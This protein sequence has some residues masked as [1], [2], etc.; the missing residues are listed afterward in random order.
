MNWSVHG[1]Q[2]VN[3]IVGVKG[4]LNIKV[5][6]DT[7]NAPLQGE[8]IVTEVIIKCKNVVVPLNT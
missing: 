8:S 7:I 1:E 4:T 5:K 6:K 3:P 2:S